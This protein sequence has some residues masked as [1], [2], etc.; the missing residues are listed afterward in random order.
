M[1]KIIMILG[2]MLSISTSFAF[3]GRESINQQALFAFKTEFNGATNAAWTAGSDFYKVEFTMNGNRLFAYYNKSG[4][5]MAVTCYISSFQLPHYLQRKLKNS[6]SNYWI[7]NLFKISNHDET[8]YYVT[9][10]NA[11]SKIVLK[12]DD[13]SKWTVFQKTEK[14]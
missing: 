3:T 9:L 1:K 13:G 6:W 8:S 2:L 7:S 14:I 10:E 5:F 12:S 11:D 4:E